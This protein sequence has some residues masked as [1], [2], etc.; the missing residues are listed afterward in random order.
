[1]KKIRLVG[2]LLT[3]LLCTTVMAQEESE[4][5]QTEQT[6]DQQ[7]VQEIK[8]VTDKLR[9]SLYKTRDG[10]SATIKLLTSGDALQLLE[11]SGNYA[12]VKTDSGLIGWVKSGF[13]VSEP[14]ASFQL[15]EEKKKNEILINQ[16]EQF[17]DTKTLVNDYETTISLMQSDQETITRRAEELQQQ[18]QQSQ[19]RAKD[20]QEQL[21]ANQQGKLG[22]Q[23]IMRVLQEFWYVL[24]LTILILFL[25][26]LVVGKKIVE[27]Q[28]R[29]RFQGVKVW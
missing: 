22:L 28:V 6:A 14:T 10:N 13:L 25:L 9:L 12:K 3:C 11:L 27:A 16:L 4:N 5:T 19:D 7:E 15:I 20:L 24:A 23:D 8:Y 29:S 21:A 17:S 18:L 1:M 2:Y 26:G